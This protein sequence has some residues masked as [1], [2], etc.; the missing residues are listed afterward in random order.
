ML[1]ACLQACEA[2]AAPWMDMDYDADTLSTLSYGF[3]SPATAS[4]TSMSS[5]KQNSEWTDEHSSGPVDP[6]DEVR[7][8]PEAC[9]HTQTCSRFVIA[10]D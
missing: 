3:G 9:P 4:R 6:E 5:A 10:R 2:Y 8:H 7:K 1:V